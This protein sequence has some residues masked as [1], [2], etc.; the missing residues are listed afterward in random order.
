MG[1]SSHCLRQFFRGGFKLLVEH[2][3]ELVQVAHVV[4]NQILHRIFLTILSGRRSIAHFASRNSPSE[5]TSAALFLGR[6]IKGRVE[7]LHGGCKLRSATIAAPT[8]DRQ[9]RSAFRCQDASALP[10]RR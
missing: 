6:C 1:S 5:M 2:L 8:P 3:A 7:E 9:A 10:E 4:L